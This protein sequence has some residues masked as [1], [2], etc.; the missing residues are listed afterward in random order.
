M[1]HS[2]SARATSA[3]RPPLSFSPTWRHVRNVSARS[4]TQPTAGT[5]IPS[6]IAPTAVPV[7]RSSPRSPT[8]ARARRCAILSC[9]PHAGANTTTLRTDASTPSRMHVLSA[10]R[11][12]TCGTT[13][14]PAWPHTGRRSNERRNC[15]EP[16]ERS[17]LRAWADSIW[18]A[19]QP[20][21]GRCA[22][23][24]HESGAKK[25]HLPC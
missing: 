17:P 19:M 18:S 25:N 12:R 5:G 2:R 8:I 22:S 3:G 24:E 6:R 10:D 7:L 9:A 11:T 13:P 14:G 4:S 23:S 15:S 1:H 20:T 16:G 21:L